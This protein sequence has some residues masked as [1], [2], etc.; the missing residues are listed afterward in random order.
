M[1][2]VV[3]LIVIVNMFTG[4]Y[5]MITNLEVTDLHFIAGCILTLLAITLNELIKLNEKSNVQ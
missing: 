2:T 1:R 5:T 3:K 4:L